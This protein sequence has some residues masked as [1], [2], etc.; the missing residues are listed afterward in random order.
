MDSSGYGKALVVLS[1]GQDSTTC[2]YL[3][4]EVGYQSISAISFDYGQR[5]RRELEAAET[6]VRLASVESHEIIRVDGLLKSTSPLVDH[7]AALEQYTDHTQMEQVIGDR[8]ELTFVPMRNALFLTVAA[9]RAVAL[10]CKDVYIGVCQADNANYPDC[11]HSFL[12]WQQGAINAALGDPNRVHLSAPLLHMAKPDSVKLALKLP[13][14]YV[15]L[16][17]SHTAYDG[18]YPPSGADHATVLR[19]HAFE[20][21]GFPDPLIV[22]AWL[23]K[24]IPFL[25]HTNNYERHAEVLYSVS[26]QARQQVVQN[27]IALLEHHFV[28]VLRAEE[29]GAP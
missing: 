5:H 12:D 16:A 2:L 11:T 20:V 8:V 1:G 25:P 15:A 27:I 21:A 17:Y 22:R 26:V 28:G 13:G 7:G 3:A 10:G 9:N 4:R 6:I 23:E 24:R 14:C 29:H 18:S 19:A